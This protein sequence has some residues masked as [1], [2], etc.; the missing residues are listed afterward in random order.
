[1]TTQ[2]RTRSSNTRMSKIRADPHPTEDQRLVRG[3]DPEP[4]DLKDR[5]PPRPTRSP[6]STDQNER[7]DQA[8]LDAIAFGRVPAETGV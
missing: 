5:R 7:D 1:M 6:A 3:I 4:A 2:S 8:V